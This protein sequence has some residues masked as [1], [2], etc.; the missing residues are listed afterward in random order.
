[1]LNVFWQYYGTLMIH[2]NPVC[3]PIIQNS[4]NLINDRFI[5]K[6]AFPEIFSIK[7]KLPT[8]K[9]VKEFPRIHTTIYLENLSPRRIA[10]MSHSLFSRQSEERRDERI[11]SALPTYI[12]IICLIE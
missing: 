9:S 5:F 2:S 4:N 8:I 1:M 3:K 6:V 7:F 11:K 10:E 12:L